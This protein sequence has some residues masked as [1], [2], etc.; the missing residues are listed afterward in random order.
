M[1]NFIKYALLTTLIG[2]ISFFILCRLEINAH[3]YLRNWLSPP[4][5]VVIEPLS[6]RCFKSRNDSLQGKQQFKANFVPGI[7]VWEAHTCYDFASLFKPTRYPY[8]GDQFYNYHTYWSYNLTQSNFDEKQLA[9]IRS[10]S[11]TQNASLVIWIP[12]QDEQKL[13]DSPYWQQIKKERIQYKIIQPTILTKDTPIEPYTQLWRELVSNQNDG[14]GKDDLLRMIVLY[15]YGGI[16]FDLDTLFIRDLSPLFEHEW[17]A[18]GSCFTG[19]FGNPFTGG[20]FHFK[21]NSP[22]VCEILEGAADLFKARQSKDKS[23]IPKRYLIS[24]PEIFG[25]KLYYR[26]YRRIL[27]HN[28]KP[29]S[30]LPW[31]FTDPSQ[32][33]RSNSLPSLFSKN[34]KFDE[35]RILQPFSYHWRDHWS[36]SPGNLF[37]YINSLHQ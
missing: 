1:I 6:S 34:S 36:S 15:R 10:F 4:Q 31:C 30:I 7:P 24:G 35:K 22:Y 19:M 23:N 27:H 32:C 37:N 16:W 29:W 28:I 11:A 2:G 17:I 20:I 26:I 21:E 3:V 5:K 33:R 14:N 13:L 25:S 9:T 18:Q 8:D 12:E